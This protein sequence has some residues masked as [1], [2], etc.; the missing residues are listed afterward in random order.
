MLNDF[1][2]HTLAL[3]QPVSSG[4]RQVVSGKQS[5]PAFLWLAVPCKQKVGKKVGGASIFTVRAVCLK[6]NPLLVT[7]HKSK[8]RF[9][10]KKGLMAFISANSHTSI[11][12]HNSSNTE[13]LRLLPDWHFDVNFRY[14]RLPETGFKVFQFTELLRQTH[15]TCR[16]HH[17][18]RHGD[19]L[20]TH[21]PRICN[22]QY[23]TG[24]KEKHNILS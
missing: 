14:F 15:E 4:L 10:R 16:H 7:S 5:K 24:N 18:R 23:M 12:R 6:W 13:L 19:Y 3:K 9:K 20:Y 8:S 17:W 21:W 22:K 2:L 11:I 1:N